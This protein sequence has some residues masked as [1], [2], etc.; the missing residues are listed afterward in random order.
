MNDGDVLG[1]CGVF[2]SGSRQ[3]TRHIT[4]RAEEGCG[5]GLTEPTRTKYFFGARYLWGRQAT[6]TDGMSIAN[7][8]RTDVSGV[9]QWVHCFVVPRLCACR[10]I[11][12][13][14]INETAMNVYHTGEEGLAQHYDSSNR[15]QPPIVSLRLF[16]DSRLTFGAKKL[17]MSNPEY[18]VPLPR[19]CVTSMI[20]DSFDT[21]DERLCH[22][23][24]NT[25]LE[26]SAS[27]HC[28]VNSEPSSVN[29]DGKS[30]FVES[31][32]DYASIHERSS[33]LNPLPSQQTRRLGSGPG[34]KHCIRPC[35]LK[36]KSASIILRQIHP[37][38]IEKANDY[39]KQQGQYSSIMS[40]LSRKYLLH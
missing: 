8:I 9:P 31:I 1:R 38:L 14:F 25:M 16:S 6:D 12:P 30:G 5:V 18:F 40:I 39:V 32:S 29:G 36:G 28:I 2:S 35:D 3:S 23:Q 10:I 13:E 15:F 11:T 37:E 21:C 24:D 19:G 7:G 4:K 33:L 26:S 27:K 22:Q 34:F 17:G 20:P